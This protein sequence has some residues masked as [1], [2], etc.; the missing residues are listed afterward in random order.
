MSLLEEI[1]QLH[2]VGVALGAGMGAVCRGGLDVA[3]IRRVGLTRLPWAT[4]AVN[5]VGTFVL[6]LVLGWS[7]AVAADRMSSASQVEDALTLELVIG[8][9]FAGGLTTFSTFSW[10]SFRLVGEGRQRAM[11][12]YAGLTLGLTL[13]AVAGGIALGGWLG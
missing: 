4:L 13:L 7:A 11:L 8:T 6:G 3:L 2:L 5:V 10:E 1:S 12:T 9:G